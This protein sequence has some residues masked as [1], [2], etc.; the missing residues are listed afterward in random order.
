MSQIASIRDLIG[1]WPTRRA[2]VD[3]IADRFPGGVSI[4]QVNKWAEKGVIPAKYHYPV[5]TA[6]IDRDLPVTADLIVRLHAP[7]ETAA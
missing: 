1:L 6:A 4:H 7:R 3:D 5:L 2:F